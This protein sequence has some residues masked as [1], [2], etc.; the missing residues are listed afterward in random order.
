MDGEKFYPDDIDDK[1]Q[2]SEC[3]MKNIQKSEP[4]EL[5]EKFFFIL[6]EEYIIEAC[7]E[8]K[9]DLQL[10]DLNTFIGIIILSSISNR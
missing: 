3:V 1:S 8:N 4:V 2:L 6:M 7:K 10:D 9:F 5:F